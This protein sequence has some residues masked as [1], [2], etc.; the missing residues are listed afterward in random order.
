MGF[1]TVGGLELLEGVMV[2]STKGSMKRLCTSARP[3][4]LYLDWAA[5]FSRCEFL[6]V[7]GVV[8]FWLSDRSLTRDAS[9]PNVIRCTFSYGAKPEVAS[10]RPKLLRSLSPTS[11]TSG[12]DSDF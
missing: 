8:D 4:E 10:R 11:E 9:A 7:V 2:E 1:G 12:A 3:S 6:R 5:N